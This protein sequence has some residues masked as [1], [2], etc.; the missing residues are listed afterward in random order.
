MLDFLGI[1][2]QKAGTTWL[3]ANLR[4]HPAIAFPAGKE[5]HFWDAN[6][7]LGIDWYRNL[8]PH[9]ENRRQGEITPAY[10][11]LPIALIQE[12]Y[13]FN[14]L[15]KLIYIVRNPRDRAW[16]SALMA[17]K[18]AE[19]TFEEASDQWFIDHFN[20]Q[21]SRMRGNYRQCIANWTSVF[22]AAQL[23]I[24]NYDDISRRPH[25]LL[26]QCCAHLGVNVSFFAENAATSAAL[27]QRVF[28][29]EGHKLRESLKA[30][31]EALYPP[32]QPYIGA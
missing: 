28:S 30:H 7:A 23:L 4:K 25:A 15:L 8:F 32:N 17:L 2:A 26:Q 14:P 21:G 18:R 6:Y 12:I 24:L 20:S 13:R 5:V 3:Y 16:S 27:Q 31:L 22:P 11:I 29:G 1:G 19:M 9:Q 10:A